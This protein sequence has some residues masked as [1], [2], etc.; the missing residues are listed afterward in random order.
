MLATLLR[1]RDLL[2][3]PVEL[4][5]IARTSFRALGILPQG[6]LLYM[7]DEDQLGCGLKRNLVQKVAEVEYNMSFLSAFL[8]SA[9][10]GP[11]ELL[12]YLRMVTRCEVGGALLLVP[13]CTIKSRYASGI[14]R[15]LRYMVEV[16][17]CLLV[18]IG[19][20]TEIYW[21]VMADQDWCPYNHYDG[22]II[23]FPAGPPSV[24]RSASGF[25]VRETGCPEISPKFEKE[26]S[27]HKMSMEY[28]RLLW[29]Q[30]R[31]W[32]C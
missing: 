21:V 29:S 13:L 9:R 22:K 18:A 31:N 7:T 1:K 8:R 25:K 28:A 5:W 15:L 23:V 6:V 14:S 11:P 2:F 30:K 10:Y 27:H 32:I 20:L 17:N 24:G 3:Q 12:A 4:V 19:R 26:V 16:Q